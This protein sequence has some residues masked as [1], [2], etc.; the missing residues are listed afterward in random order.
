MAGAGEGNDLTPGFLGDNLAHT[1]MGTGFQ[2]LGDG[3]HN[4]ILVNERCHAT[5]DAAHG[6][7][8][9]GD[10]H[11]LASADAGIVAGDLQ[12]LGQV[13]TGESGVAPGGLHLGD[14]ILLKGP[15]G[16]IVTV[17]MQ[18]DRQGR[19]PGTAANNTNFHFCF[20]FPPPRL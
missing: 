5:A 2:T 17:Q 3:Y 8:G 10:D 9:G 20:P 13:G 7:G 19:A 15:H 18:T 11:Q 12:T 6:E 1:H 16:D 4:S 14:Q